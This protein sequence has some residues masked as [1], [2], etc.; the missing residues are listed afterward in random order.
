MNALSFEQ[1]ESVQAECNRLV[2]NYFVKDFDPIQAL[3]T[4]IGNCFAKAVVACG[5]IEVR[6]GFEPS[7]VYSERLHGS[8]LKSDK[9]ID[10]KTHKR[11][12]HIVVVARES[13]A[14]DEFHIPGLDYGM[15]ELE[16]REKMIED[17]G[18]MLD[19]NE[20]EDFVY[21]DLN[22]EVVPT[23][24]G[25]EHGITAGFWRQK[26]SEYLAVLDREPVD[27]EKFFAML[28]E[29]GVMGAVRT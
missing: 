25:R 1:F 12:A 11:M 16:R 19:Y 15:V 8:D 24:N 14:P 17:P 27:F 21:A 22:G 13:G 4:G 3:E 26:S 10:P 20:A 7:M 9:P 2:P 5:V 18:N 29:R 23:R 28:G 6:Y